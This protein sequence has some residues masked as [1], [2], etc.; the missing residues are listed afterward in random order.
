MFTV[1]V[2]NYLFITT[3]HAIKMHKYIR[4][5]DYDGDEEASGAHQ[6]EYNAMTCEGDRVHVIEIFESS[7]EDGKRAVT[8]ASDA[9]CGGDNPLLVCEV[10]DSS[11]LRNIITNIHP[12]H[13][14]KMSETLK[15]R[16]NDL[17]YFTESEIWDFL[18][19][20][21]SVLLHLNK[22]NLSHGNITLQSVGIYNNSL[23]FPFP[24]IGTAYK[25]SD[26][27]FSV[28]V[29]LNEIS[30]LQLQQTVASRYSV[31]LRFLIKKMCEESE[32][33]RPKAVQIANYHSV[34]K[35]MKQTPSPNITQSVQSK[36]TEL[37][38]NEII[39]LRN[40][41]TQMD[42]SKETNLTDLRGLQTENNHLRE[43]VSDLQNSETAKFSDQ[44]AASEI[45]LIRIELRKVVSEY[46]K[47]T[48]KLP[49]DKNPFWEG[50]LSNEVSQLQ[51]E[52]LRLNRILSSY[53][54]READ[55]AEREAKVSAFLKLY[56]MT[57]QQ[58]SA[59]PSNQ[60]Q[61]QLFLDYYSIPETSETRSRSEDV[62]QNQFVEE[63]SV[64]SN[65]QQQQSERSP[66]TDFINND[67]HT[68]ISQNQQTSEAQVPSSVCSA[69]KSHD[70]TRLSDSDINR[71]RPC[72]EGSET[73]QHESR[74]SPSNSRSSP[75]NSRSSPSNSRSIGWQTPQV[76]RQSSE[77]ETPPSHQLTPH[78]S[79]LKQSNQ[80]PSSTK[81]RVRWIDDPPPI[82]VALFASSPS[83]K[84]VDLNITTDSHKELQQILLTC[85][86]DTSSLGVRPPSVG[87]AG[88]QLL[89]C[90]PPSSNNSNV[91][92]VATERKL[93]LSPPSSLSNEDL[94]V[95]SEDVPPATPEIIFAAS[96]ASPSTDGRMF[97]P[98][99]TNINTLT[100]NVDHL[101]AKYSPVGTPPLPSP[102]RRST[103]KGNAIIARRKRSPFGSSVTS[104]RQSIGRSSPSGSSPSSRRIVAV[105]GTKNEASFGTSRSETTNLSIES[106]DDVIVS[107]S[108]AEGKNIIIIPQIDIQTIIEKKKLLTATSTATR[109]SCS[110][111]TSS[112]SVLQKTEESISESNGL[113]YSKGSIISTEFDS[114]E[115]DVVTY[116]E[117]SSD[118]DI[119]QGTCAGAIAI[120]VSD[121]SIT[122]DVVATT[123]TE[124][125]SVVCKASASTYS[126][127]VSSPATKEMRKESENDG[128]ETS[129][130]DYTESI[131]LMEK[132]NISVI[133]SVPERVSEDEKQPTSHPSSQRGELIELRVPIKRTEHPQRESQKIQI[134]LSLNLEQTIEEISS[135]VVES[136]VEEEKVVEV[137]QSILPNINNKST[138]DENS[139]IPQPGSYTPY[140]VDEDDQIPFVSPIR[141]SKSA[142]GVVSPSVRGS[143]NSEAIHPT[144]SFSQ[145]PTSNNKKSA[146]IYVTR[147]PAAH[148]GADSHTSPSYSSDA[149][150]TVTATGGGNASGGSYSNYSTSSYVSGGDKN[151]KLEKER[152]L[153][154]S[155]PELP[156]AKVVA[157]T[158]EIVKS[159]A[160]LNQKNNASRVKP[161]KT[162]ERQLFS[163]SADEQ[164]SVDYLMN[165]SNMSVFGMPIRQFVS[166]EPKV[167]PLDDVSPPSVAKNT[168]E[169]GHSLFGFNSQQLKVAV[170]VDSTK[171][172]TVKTPQT[173]PVRVPRT[174]EE[175][176]IY[177]LQRT[178]D[179][180]ENMYQPEGRRTPDRKP[181][182][183]SQSTPLQRC[184]FDTSTGHLIKP[185]QQ[186]S[187]KGTLH[188]KLA[189]LEDISQRNK[190]ARESRERRSQSNTILTS[191]TSLAENIRSNLTFGSGSTPPTSARRTV[192][193]TPSTRAA[194]QT[195][196]TE[197]EQ[198]DSQLEERSV[199]KS[200]PA[201]ARARAARTRKSVL[202]RTTRLLGNPSKSHYNADVYSPASLSSVGGSTSNPSNSNRGTHSTLRSLS[203]T[204]GSV[205]SLSMS[206][207]ARV[208]SAIPSASPSDVVDARDLL[209]Q[210]R[211]ERRSQKRQS[212]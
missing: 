17:N 69:V 140:S 58:L 50:S 46:Q 128:N 114:K 88:D 177:H 1:S 178:P 53:Q 196:T 111:S 117:I 115:K 98:Q 174:H 121:D 132:S 190:L 138:V 92:H 129:K 32:S 148:T 82:E 94:A 84:S 89:T 19:N 153:D 64:E 151:R 13:A 56:N 125:G 118:T 126:E 179:K 5:V 104:V 14:V 2:I 54:S 44:P 120:A 87:P 108:P 28:G 4:I 9:I 156:F 147:K 141:T 163:T 168:T 15:L 7:G 60:K 158:D 123:Y 27:V 66:S 105:V 124:E 33:E 155:V 100:N 200:S 79:S 109:T 191:R 35:R 70:T 37:L 142:I 41:I 180:H 201:D 6:N 85:S 173:S 170:E 172:R 202:A 212:S 106:S 160:V 16:T 167:M 21:I 43:L 83:V 34:K 24:N 71:S 127:C 49:V 195:E 116:S 99:T 26:D 164:P 91:F 133:E 81:S 110:V 176:V 25:P 12:Q 181:L 38:K 210:L 86:S 150:P 199:S 78:Q 162:C 137:R 20:S 73:P 161:A 188:S 152:L 63:T 186:R 52:I 112:T 18:V 47:R 29:L 193:T 175:L 146:D 93:I 207:E 45:D 166:E 76:A 95:P 55:I 144:D 39:R 136:E 40:T 75:S 204:V 74:S 23:L 171:E 169:C 103:P 102:V 113:K 145:T 130:Q 185:W 31:D 159:P 205:P 3:R 96:A 72:W 8:M 61:Q 209:R 211:A 131:H 65:Q 22:Y 183:N 67:S 187:I 189:E 62:A 59:V 80:I 157:P 198:R 206:P 51:E 134:P 42:E 197:L 11:E 143:S 119:H 203:S 135:E 90:T 184:R 68:D 192:S 122:T 97:S 57:A 139:D 101:I 36:E 165:E 149:T 30:T 107:T 182:D 194:N 48:N 208:T 77:N 154:D 10:V